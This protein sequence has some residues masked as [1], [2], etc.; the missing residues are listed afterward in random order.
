MALV[1]HY[2]FELYQM[3]AK[4]IVE[5]KFGLRGLQETTK[6]PTYKR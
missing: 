3:D 4:A 6:I 5:W 1:A 2:N